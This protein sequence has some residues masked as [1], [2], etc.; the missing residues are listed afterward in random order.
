MTAE[1]GCISPPD[2][3]LDYAALIEDII[4]VVLL[5]FHGKVRGEI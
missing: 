3:V 4:V 2:I 1:S 5:L